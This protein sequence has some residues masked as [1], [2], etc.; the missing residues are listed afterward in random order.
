MGRLNRRRLPL[1][2]LGRPGRPAPQF[3]PD[4]PALQLPEEPAPTGASSGD[5]TEFAIVSV[6]G[7]GTAS[8]PASPDEAT[9]EL[10]P[11]RPVDAPDG[12]A[13][14]PARMEFA[15]P[16]GAKLIA[17]RQTYDKHSRCSMCQTVLLLN[18]VY[19]P[20]LGSH[21]IVPFR[22]DPNAPL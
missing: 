9:A 7:N 19:D 21:E 11:V 16:C 4:P 22:V 2:R 5:S 1:R 8:P 3:P 18:L 12:E 20:E 13:A 10:P 6:P 14:P 15:C 17:T